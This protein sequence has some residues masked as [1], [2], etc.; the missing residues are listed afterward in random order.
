MKRS[1]DKSE[2]PNDNIVV[3]RGHAAKSLAARC[4]DARSALWPPLISAF[5]HA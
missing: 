1:K 4:K 2:A 5:V 3:S